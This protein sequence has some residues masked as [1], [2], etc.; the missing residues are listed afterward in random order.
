MRKFSE[1]TLERMI[2]IVLGWRKGKRVSGRQ[3]GREAGR[4]GSMSDRSE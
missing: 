4:Q 1:E 3:G 2:N